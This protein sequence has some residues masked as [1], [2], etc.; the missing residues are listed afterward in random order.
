M[1]PRFRDTGSFPRPVGSG[2]LKGRRRESLSRKKSK[3][4]RRKGSKSTAARSIILKRF[5]SG[6]PNRY[7]DRIEPFDDPFKD[8]F[9]LDIV[10]DQYP[11]ACGEVRFEFEQFG[12]GLAAVFDI[13]KQPKR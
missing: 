9:E 5:S 11:A 12:G 13:T 1:R 4:S 7:A 10:P 6:L 3:C 2:G 8:I